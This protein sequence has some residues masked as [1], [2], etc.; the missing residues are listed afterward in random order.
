ML[1]GHVKGVLSIG[2][3]KEVVVSQRSFRV[4]KELGRLKGVGVAQLA[5]AYSSHKLS[6]SLSSPDN[7]YAYTNYIQ[8][9]LYHMLSICSV[10][11]IRIGG[12]LR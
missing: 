3:R 1:A 2:V 10:T 7:V 5:R 9:C 12:L 4:Q 6:T 11:R 8:F